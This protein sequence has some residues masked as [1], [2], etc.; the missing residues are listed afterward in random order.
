MVWAIDYHLLVRWPCSMSVL[1]PLMA[2]RVGFDPLGLPDDAA[3]DATP[4]DT[5]GPGAC[6]LPSTLIC[7]PFENGI[8]ANAVDGGAAWLAGGGRD[9]GGAF[10]ASA[11]SSLNALAIYSWAAPITD[12]RL[13]TRFYARL[14]AGAPIAT[15]AVL[16]QLDNGVDTMGEEKISADLVSAD[17]YAVALPFVGG[18]GAGTEVAPRA[19]WLCMELA[20]L[21]DATGN[22]GTVQWLVN[23]VEVVGSGPERTMVPG[24]FAQLFLGV[25]LGAADPDFE[26]L[27]D[28]LVV[29]REPIGC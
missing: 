15:Y 26:V 2:C 19:S 17:R 21:V 8:A 14:G 13:H 1:L 12:G 20:V 16:V 5:S 27:F 28:D 23:G 6:A 10:R 25:S 18:G 22:S 11:T 7:D 29:A 3:T 9:G 24:G 4:S